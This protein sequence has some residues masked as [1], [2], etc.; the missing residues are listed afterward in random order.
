MKLNHM[1]DAK[2]KLNCKRRLYLNVFAF[3]YNKVKDSSSPF[4]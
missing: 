1:A 4:M 2:G 3:C